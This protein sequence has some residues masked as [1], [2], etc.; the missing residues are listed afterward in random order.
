MSNQFFKVM[1]RII[2]HRG[3]CG[4]AP[5]NTIASMEKALELGTNSVEIDVMLTRDDQCVICHDHNVRRCTN[6]EGKVR[7]KTLSEIQSLDAGSWFAPEFADARIPTL[8]EAFKRLVELG[9]SVNLEIKPLE[10]WQVPTA[11]KVLEELNTLG[12]KSPPTLISSF[13]IEALEVVQEISPEIPRGYLTDVLP[14]EWERR[15]KAVGAVSLHMDKDFVTPEIVKSVQGAGIKLLIYTVNDAE[16]AK[17]LL[18]WGVD[19]II[20][21]YPDRLLPLL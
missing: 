20:T 12:E 3:A 8:T 4:H 2:G 13:D 9:M 19:A 5:E 15:L 1:P 7:L 18:D 21:D 6:G 17:P 14:D 10:G 11:R 16:T